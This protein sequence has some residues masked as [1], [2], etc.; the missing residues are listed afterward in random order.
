MDDAVEATLA[1]MREGA[2]IIYQATLRDGPFL[3]HADF[4]R[5]VPLPSALGDYSY[6]VIDTK[7][8]RSAKARYLVHLCFYSELLWK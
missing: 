4:L 2:D 5:R 6:E 8:A 3:G 1:A 7:L